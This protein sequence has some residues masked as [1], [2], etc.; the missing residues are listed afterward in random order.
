MSRYQIWDKTSQV[1]T[2]IGEV[3]SPEEWMERY[4]MSRVNGIDL[5]IAG[6]TINGAFCGEYTSMVDMY[7]KQMKQSGLEE[8][9]E[10]IPEGMSPQA[11]LDF[12]E[13]FEDARNVPVDSVTAEDRIAAALEA[14][15]MMNLPDENE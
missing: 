11:T 5:V 7:D 8:Y 15:V 2:P 3:L 6:G 1:I 9:A 13:A 14:Q 4:P 10:G 12:I